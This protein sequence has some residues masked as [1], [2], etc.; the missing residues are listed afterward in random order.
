[1]IVS[2]KCPLKYSLRRA[3]HEIKVP[4]ATLRLTG[5]IW[6]QPTVLE[7][8][9]RNR[10]YGSKQAVHGDREGRVVASQLEVE[11]LVR[12]GFRT[13]LAKEVCRGIENLKERIL[14]RMA[15]PVYWI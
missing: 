8:M 9:R 4:A 3:K 5:S 2:Q 15:A 13:V 11:T 7:M 10:R 14:L 12:F 6:R 1:M